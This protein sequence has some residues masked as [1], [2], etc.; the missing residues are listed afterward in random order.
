MQIFQ[1]QTLWMLVES[2]ILPI[3]N[4]VVPAVLCFDFIPMFFVDLTMLVSSQFFGVDVR[5]LGIFIE[6]WVCA[7]PPFRLSSDG[8]TSDGC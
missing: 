4:F 7:A 3:L 6:V 5:D 8:I 2:K 1:I